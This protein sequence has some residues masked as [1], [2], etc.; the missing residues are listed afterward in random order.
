MVF[1]LSRETKNFCGLVLF[2]GT[3]GA[4]LDYAHTHGGAIEYPEGT[5]HERGILTFAFVY[6]VIPQLVS[7][8]RMSTEAYIEL[9]PQKA[10]PASSLLNEAE[11]LPSLEKAI[12]AEEADILRNNYN[13]KG[14]SPKDRLR[15]VFAPNS[16]YGLAIRGKLRVPFTEEENARRRFK[17][18][19]PLAPWTATF[20]AMTLLFTS[21]YLLTAYGWNR[22]PSIGIAAALAVPTLFL[23]KKWDGSMHGLVVLCMVGLG[24]ASTEAFLNTYLGTMTYQT[25]DIFGIPYW[26]FWIYALNASTYG[27]ITRFLLEPKH[28]T[29]VFVGVDSLPHKWARRYYRDHVG[30]PNDTATEHE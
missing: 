15:H 5:H 11:V 30:L 28:R 20:P 18:L 27:H 14:G 13:C 10:H 17:R 6:S 25:N 3:Y 12:G 4:A 26:L 24:G 21:G 16:M 9:P 1:S 2:G 19:H 22:F 7:W 23:Y 8:Y 29:K